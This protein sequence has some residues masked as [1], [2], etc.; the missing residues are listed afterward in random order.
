MTIANCS[1]FDIGSYPD[2]CK[3]PS[4]LHRAKHV[5]AP[6]E[7]K[8]LIERIH[9]RARRRQNGEAGSCIHFEARETPPFSC[10]VALTRSTGVSTL[11][12]ESRGHAGFVSRFDRQCAQFQSGRDDGAGRFAAR[13]RI[14]SLDFPDAG[15]LINAGIL[16]GSARRVL[17][18][19]AAAATILAQW[20]G[21]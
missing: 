4:A 13:V 20:I 2:A 21:P 7:L 10:K 5:A 3:P 17:P 8:D 9:V 1:G 15:L 6:P 19:P 11:L 14:S 12:K 16:P 18:N